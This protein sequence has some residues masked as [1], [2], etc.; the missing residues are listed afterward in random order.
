MPRYSTS[1]VNTTSG[2][3]SI[4]NFKIDSVF[5]TKRVDPKGTFYTMAIYRDSAYEFVE[6]LVICN[7]GNSTEAFIVTYSRIMHSNKTKCTIP[8]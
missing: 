6:N 2:Q 5:V 1:S 7:K 8:F 4:Y 3:S